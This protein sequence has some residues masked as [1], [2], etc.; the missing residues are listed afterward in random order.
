MRLYQLFDFFIFDLRWVLDDVITSTIKSPSES[1][2]FKG[3]IIHGSQRRLV[4][5]HTFLVS[6]TTL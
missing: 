6:L 4:A 1:L 3:E 2:V 5:S